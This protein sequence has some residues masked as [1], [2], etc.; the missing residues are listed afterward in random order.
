MGEWPFEFDKNDMMLS[1][2]QYMVHKLLERKNITLIEEENRA[3]I[4]L[5]IEV[6]EARE[7]GA[8][9]GM[10]EL[11]RRSGLSVS[12]IPILE[13]G[14]ALPDEITPEV[15]AS[16]AAALSIKIQDLERAYYFY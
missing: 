14:K 16:L 1:A 6:S 11:A 9:I 13:A 3:L 4:A 15:L 7:E 10:R 8:G 12:F 5:G 2:N